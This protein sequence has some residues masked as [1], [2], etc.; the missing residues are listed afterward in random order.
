MKNE[1]GYFVFQDLNHFISS[2]KELNGLTHIDQINWY[3]KTPNVET[4]RFGYLKMLKEYEQLSEETDKNK[5]LAFQSKYSS[6]DSIAHFKSTGEVEMNVPIQYAQIVNKNGLVKIGSMLIHS[7]KDKTAYIFDGDINKLESAMRMNGGDRT[8]NIAVVKEQVVDGSGLRGTCIGGPGQD[9][10]ISQR[11]DAIGSPQAFKTE[12]RLAIQTWSFPKNDGS[13]ASNSFVVYYAN[14]KSYKRGVFGIWFASS[15]TK[16]CKGSVIV[17]ASGC[18]PGQFCFVTNPNYS[19]VV[20]GMSDV[21]Y[22]IAGAYSYYMTFVPAVD[23]PNFYQA[24]S[25]NM[26]IITSTSKGSIVQNMQ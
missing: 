13:L 22:P 8:N 14:A 9:I 19:D 18:T 16:E 17:K 7:A 10:T 3:E 15:L 12:S 2:M 11:T 23:A 20:S 6:I 21:L 4:L 1:N 25:D 26:Q 5:I 24:C